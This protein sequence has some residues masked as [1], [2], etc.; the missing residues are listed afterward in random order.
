MLSPP[1]R[2]SGH[3]SPLP[4]SWVQLVADRFQLPEQTIE[5]ARHRDAAYRCHAL[6]ISAEEAGGAEREVAAHRIGPE[7][8]PSSLTSSRYSPLWHLGLA[9]G[10]ART[11]GDEGPRPGHCGLSAGGCTV[12]CHAEVAG[13]GAVV[14]Q[15]LELP[16]PMSREI[17]S[18]GPFAVKRLDL[19]AP[20][21]IGQ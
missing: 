10:R 7:C 12:A 4:S 17:R 14:Q 16:S 20:R 6:A 9:V 18:G 11:P 13:G 21:H 2:I 15:G 3:R 19:H 5:V 8:R 1:K